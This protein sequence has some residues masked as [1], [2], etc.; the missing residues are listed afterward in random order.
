METEGRLESMRIDFVKGTLREEDVD[1][2]PLKQ[3]ETWLK[4]ALDG[5]NPLANAMVL[6][7]VGKDGMPSSRVMLLR[8]IS[9]GGLTFFTNYKSAKAG[10]L[11]DNPQASVLFFWQESERQVRVEGNT[12][13][14]DPA[15][16]DAYFRQ[17]PFE[18]KVG[19]WVSA[20]S[21]RVESREALDTAFDQA[22]AR[23]E[24]T[25]VPRPPHWG[26]Y[27]LKPVVFEFWQGRS[28][29]LHDRLRYRK[30]ALS[31]EWIIERLMP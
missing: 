18:S 27:V 13:F 25:E 16:S 20:Q 4:E 2:D 22:L 12:V 24:G 9:H 28:S 3:F 8:D 17:R 5:G 6:S 21:S 15:E 31:G 19:A 7:T 10:D 14:I 1:R 23:F 29:R 30:D 11:A 26:G